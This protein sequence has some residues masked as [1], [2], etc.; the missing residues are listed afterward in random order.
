VTRAR[1]RLALAVQYA[2][3]HD[4]LPPPARLS[5]WARAAI[6]RDARLTL[7]FVGRPEGRRLNALYRGK[8]YATNVLAFVYDGATAIQGD[9]VLCA[10][11]LRREAALQRK[12]LAEHCA[13]LVVHGILHLQGYD[14]DT[15]RGAAA[16]EARETAILAALGIADPYAGRAP[17]RR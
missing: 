7:R 4:A 1:P 17:A 10:P 5:R 14:H 2:V 3:R 16:M 9:V 8:D 12:T 15:E 13:H 6:E 11:V